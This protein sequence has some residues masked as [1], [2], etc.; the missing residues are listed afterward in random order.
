MQLRV[1][2]LSQQAAGVTTA[3]VITQ[4]VAPSTVSNP[5]MQPPSA[6]EQGRAS[7]NAH[8]DRKLPVY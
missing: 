3:N 4:P 6:A 5:N 1:W 2:R 8:D 7:P